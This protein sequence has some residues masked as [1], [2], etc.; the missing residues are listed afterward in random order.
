MKLWAII[1]LLV[2]RSVLASAME[3]SYMP[4]WRWKKNFGGKVKSIKSTGHSPTCKY[5]QTS[6]GRYP[7][8]LESPALL[9]SF[10]DYESFH[11]VAAD[12][13]PFSEG[14]QKYIHSPQDIKNRYLIFSV[15]TCSTGLGN[16]LLPLISAYLLAM[17]TRRV[18]LVDFNDYSVDEILCNPLGNSS[19]SFPQNVKWSKIK[20]ADRGGGSFAVAGIDNDKTYKMATLTIS[21]RTD[22]TTIDHLVC[23]GDLGMKWRNVQ[24]VRVMSNYYLV[25]ALFMNPFYRKHL[26]A[27]FP[28]HN[29]ARQLLRYLI[30]PT[31]QIFSQVQKSLATMPEGFYGLQFRTFANHLDM[32]AV[33]Q[34]VKCIETTLGRGK[35]PTILVASLNADML[36]KYIS[37]RRTWNVTYNYA[38]GIQIPGKDQAANALHDVFVL[39]HA[40]ELF[41]SPRSTLGYLATA[42]RG[43]G[44]V[45][46]PG[47]IHANLATDCKRDYSSEPCFHRS[48]SVLETLC[49]NHND[50]GLQKSNLDRLF[51]PC[52]DT[53]GFKLQD[54]H[55]SKSVRAQKRK[56]VDDEGSRFHDQLL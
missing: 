16:R 6:H 49:S 15:R 28:H 40:R 13:E 9:A 42:L 37:D 4:R 14:L 8:E 11:A 50:L 27:L 38:D 5:K 41:V 56:L 55:F 35:D 10:K 25:P 53:I 22:A 47:G 51:I 33:D 24:I 2:A 21:D 32:K 30:V 48:L 52:Q 26:Q 12:S 39:A 19:W 46:I 18:L 44:A 54:S 29:V 20:T 31:D 43:G 7:D 3:G 34:A 45:F 17:L 36:V 23:D 1:T